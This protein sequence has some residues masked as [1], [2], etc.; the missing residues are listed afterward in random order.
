MTSDRDNLVKL[1][2]KFQF[3]LLLVAGIVIATGAIGGVLYSLVYPSGQRLGIIASGLATGG[4]AFSL[5][6]FLGF[7]FGLPKTIQSEKL[8][9]DRR[10]YLA[11]TNLEQISDWLTKILVGVGLI[12]LGQVSGQLGRLGDALAPMFGSGPSSAGFAL[13][14]CIY[15]L[16]SS[17]ILMYLWTRAGFPTVLRASDAYLDE[18]IEAKIE[19]AFSSRA[20]ANAKALSLAERQLNAD[21]DAPSQG[22]LDS[23]T[24]GA[25]PEWRGHLYRRAEDQRS[26]SWI[27]EDATS[28]ERHLEP[29]PFSVRS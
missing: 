10:L 24:A 6:V 1:A 28:I 17:F 4:V 9:E 11:N 25:A 12:Q 29:F 2:N 26:H 18:K 20:S 19:D 15:F 23:A 7:L 21:E 22:D 8:G 13:A 14:L 27:L 3:Q 16:V 5:G